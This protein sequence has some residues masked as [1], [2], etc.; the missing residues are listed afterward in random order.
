MGNVENSLMHEPI[1]IFGIYLKM[2]RGRLRWG[3]LKRGDLMDSS[4]T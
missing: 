3:D 2:R 1:S 4:I